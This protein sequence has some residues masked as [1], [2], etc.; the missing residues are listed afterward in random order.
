ML[1]CYQFVEHV[2]DG[3]L[4]LSI[5]MTLQKYDPGDVF[6]SILQQYIL[7]TSPETPQRTLPSNFE[8]RVRTW[9]DVLNGE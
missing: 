2:I 4:R 9:T 1:K 7:H 5:S 3:S 8:G 6:S